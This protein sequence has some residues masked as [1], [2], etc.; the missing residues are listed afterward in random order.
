MNRLKDA[1]FSWIVSDKKKWLAE[2]IGSGNKKKRG[3]PRKSLEDRG[4]PKAPKPIRAKWMNMYDKLKEYKEKYNTIEISPDETQ[5]EDLMALRTWAKNQKNMHIRWRQGHD[6]GMTQEKSDMLKELGMDFPPAWEDMYVKI[7]QY[8]A[9]H[10]NIEIASDYDPILAAWMA[11][12]NEVLGRHLQG[13][14]TR[15]SDDQAM[16]LLA[17]GFQ[18]GR[19][20]AAAVSGIDGKVNVSGKTVASRDFDVRWNEMY[21]QL[22]EWKAEHGHCNVSTTSGT[23]LAHWVSAQRRMYNKL[24]AGTP[25]KRA[26]LDALKMQR[27]TEIGFQFRP[28]GSYVS[29]DDNIKLV[30]QFRKHNGHCRIPVAH[31][32]LGSFVKL[33]RRDYKN[34]C[35]GKKTSMTSE[36]EAQLRAYD[37]IFEG[38]KT[39]QRAAGPKKAWSERLEELI[40]Y[41][42]EFGHTVV[43]QNSGQLG[44]WVHSQRVHYKKYKEGSKSQMTAERALKLTEIGFCFN[45]SD[46]YR[47][48]KRHKTSEQEAEEE[49]ILQ[50][51][52][53]AHLQQ[54]QHQQ[55]QETL[56]VPQHQGVQQH[57]AHTGDLFEQAAHYGSVEGLGV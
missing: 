4:M 6:V 13:K 45:A 30:E 43:P 29:W 16:R 19:G 32:Q 12:Q 31:P 36:R 25:G 22:R 1:G 44:A 57:N 27:L 55:L 50:Q 39:P 51:Q 18:G 34:F 7:V 24:V 5:D 15:L 38:G 20:G 40:Q 28:R 42:N 9:Q 26:V 52:Q 37:F 49:A 54:Q 11:R 14:S 35:Q 46:R 41:K 23:D 2:E 10:G 8:K 53:I 33:V 17:L 56:Y 3:R 21:Q 48:N 47:G